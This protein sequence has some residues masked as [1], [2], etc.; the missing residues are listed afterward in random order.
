MASDEHEDLVDQ[1]EHLAEAKVPVTL[2]STYSGRIILK[3]ILNNGLGLVGERLVIGGWVKSS[4]EVRKVRPETLELPSNVGTPTDVT[5]VEAIQSR[6]PFLRSIIKVF[7]GHCTNVHD[8]LDPFITKPPQPSMLYLRISDGS[9]LQ[10]LQVVVDSSLFP[11]SHLMFPGTCVLV[12]GILQQSS[13]QGKNI[14]QIK[15]E[16][17]LHVGVVDHDKYPLSRKR[18]PV[19]ASRDH[20]HFRPRTITVATVMRIR[21]ALSLGTH[22][23]FQNKGFLNVQVPIITPT[24]SEGS[25]EKFHVT[26]LLE[27]QT[28]EEKI[29]SMDETQG[30]GLQSVKP[31]VAEK[32]RQVEELSRT[33]GNKEAF[34]AALED[35]RK[36]DDLTMQL[37]AREK[38]KADHTYVKTGD[39]FSEDFFSCE[40]YLTVSGRLHLQSFACAL[41]DVYSFGPRFYAERSESKKFLAEM[42]MV[43]LEMAF[44]QLEDAMNCAN[45]LLK[46]LCTWVLEHCSEDLTFVST[47]L[48][49]TILDRLQSTATGS[50]EK[51]SYAEAINDLKKVT[52]KKFDVNIE[53]GIPL[54]E[55]L[56]C[57][58]ADEIYKRPVIIYNYPKELKPF[59]VRLN[60]DGKT[61]AAFDLIVP[62]AGTLIR[63][64]QNEERL[65]MLDS[66]IKELNL[67]KNQY[68]WYLDLRRHGTAKNSGFSLVFDLLVLYA[69][70]LNDVRDVVPF[71]RSFGKAYN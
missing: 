63:G 42:S 24:D 48:E 9:C 29:V 17:I 21:N 36:T 22:T 12:E 38:S 40:T 37:E 7:G 23:F 33:G 13:F 52:E 47:R 18:I 11:P 39:R 27:H 43:E 44:S 31:S 49:S 25:T 8:K 59:Y 32:R 67:P 14:I 5:C 16:K 71:P 70:G 54:S 69:T 62:K 56:Q 3:T 45:D 68:E 57:Y 1:P 28:K 6:I 2:P 65:D 64:S 50:F 61:V 19:D 60:D 4:K 30:V 66:R 10:S 35:V 41:G 20:E 53:H 58:I 55:E 26:T 51:I 15:A 34:A 46:F